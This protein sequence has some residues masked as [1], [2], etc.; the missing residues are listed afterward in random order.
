MS[1]E[2]ILTNEWITLV[3]HKEDNYLQITAH[4]PVDTEHFA[5]VVKVYNKGL[6]YLEKHN[7]EK[8]LSDER[9]SMT[10]EGTDESEVNEFSAAWGQRAIAAGWKYWAMVVPESLKGREKMQDLVQIFHDQGVWVALFT[11][12]DEARAWLI[13]K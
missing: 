7:I 4:K 2:T 9:K 1:A 8:W 3:Y 11:D 5:E 6:E 12:V 10:P 13:E